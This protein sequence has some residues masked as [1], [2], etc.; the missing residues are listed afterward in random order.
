MIVGK[1]DAH[2]NCDEYLLEIEKHLK[3]IGYC[4]IGYSNL[5]EDKSIRDNILFGS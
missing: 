3:F 2:P 4:K 1:I 5:I